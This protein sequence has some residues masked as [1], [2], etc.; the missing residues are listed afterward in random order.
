VTD[1]WT[2]DDSIY[3]ASIASRYWTYMKLHISK[4][5]HDL[6]C[7]FMTLKLPIVVPIHCSYILIFSCYCY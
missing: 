7:M 1:R 5:L 6:V 4:R 3:R 2:H